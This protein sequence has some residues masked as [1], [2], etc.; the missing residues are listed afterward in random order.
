[1]LQNACCMFQVAD[2]RFQVACC[3]LHVSDFRFQVSGCMQSVTKILFLEFL[4]LFSIF[5]ETPKTLVF[6]SWFPDFL[7]WKNIQ[8][9]TI[10]NCLCGD[11]S[12]LKTVKKLFL[13]NYLQDTMQKSH[14]IRNFQFQ[15]DSKHSAKFNFRWSKICCRIWI[16]PSGLVA[17][18]SL[19]LIFRY[20][21]KN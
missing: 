13:S 16:Q 3:M 12:Q 4:F 6:P 17:R 1:M 15:F 5:F 14:K 10:W 2:F 9:K 21:N 7:I 18:H 20:G 11:G 8:R 19:S